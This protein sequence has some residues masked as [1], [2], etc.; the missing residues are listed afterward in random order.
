M[1]MRVTSEID[2]SP[3][4]GTMWGCGPPA[5]APLDFDDAPSQVGDAFCV[6]QVHVSYYY[7]HLTKHSIRHIVQ[8]A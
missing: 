5:P 7:Q 8:A 2:D 4:L 3:Q 1:L 6:F